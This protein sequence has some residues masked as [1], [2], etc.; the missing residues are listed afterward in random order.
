VELLDELA[1]FLAGRYPRDFSRTATSVTVLG[2]RYE[3]PN[4]GEPDAAERALKVAALLVQDDLV[5]MMDT[6]GEYFLEGGAVCLAGFWRL[7]D[8]LG[9]SL[10]EIHLRGGVPLCEYN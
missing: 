2:E 7:R 10:D 3:L 5:I 9:L 1:T 8:K 6:D 4:G